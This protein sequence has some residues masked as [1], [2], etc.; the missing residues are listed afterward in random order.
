MLM[1]ERRNSP[2]VLVEWLDGRNL[3]NCRGGNLD[4]EDGKRTY[5]IR[6]QTILLHVVKYD[7]PK[8]IAIAIFPQFES[9]RKKKRHGRRWRWVGGVGKMLGKMLSS[10][11]VGL[12][13]LLVMYYRN[14]IYE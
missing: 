5:E 1:S 8:P 14:M 3:G 6:H 4:P 2:Y 9:V 13:L 7:I 10:N 11:H 12:C